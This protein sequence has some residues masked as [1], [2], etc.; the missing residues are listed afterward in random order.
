MIDFY[1]RADSVEALKAKLP[2]LWVDGEWVSSNGQFS[3]DIIGP[4]VKIV[5]D[6]PELIDSRFHANMRC[7]DDGIAQLVID[8]GLALEVP[9]QNPLRAW[10]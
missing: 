2:F 10:A 6:F 1:L 8:S 9:P 5:D 7:L 4:I 3:L